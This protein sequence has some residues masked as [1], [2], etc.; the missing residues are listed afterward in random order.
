MKPII[1]CDFDGVLN[2]FPYSYS[3]DTDGSHA[4][5]VEKNGHINY[6]FLREDFDSSHFFIPN[7]FTLVDSSK[8]VFPITYSSEMVTRLRNLIVE[9]VVDFVWLSTWREEAVQH[10]NPLFNFPDHVTYLNW[11]QRF[12][13]YNHA[14][15]GHAIMDYFEEH[16]DQLPRKMVWLDD[17]ATRGY[18]NWFADMG[19]QPEAT[20][21]MLS[22]RLPSERLVIQ[23]NELYGISR[24]ELD[25]IENFVK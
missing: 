7:N 20:Y 23:T 14:G 8:G 21:G 9:D 11:Q 2:Q 6:G 10:I 4:V 17:V 1:F 24:T 3:K 16:P 25:V 5:I 22:D 18:V 19:F 15:K 12:S 13:D